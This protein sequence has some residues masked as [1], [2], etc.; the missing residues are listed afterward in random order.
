MKHHLLS[1]LLLSVALPAHAVG[2]VGTVTRNGQPVYP[3]DIDIVNRTTG[4]T[5]PIPGDTTTA[6]GSYNLVLP[7]GRYNLTFRP[8]PNSHAFDAPHQD[9]RVE[10]N[11]ITVNMSLL[12]GVYVSGRV[13][14]AAGAGVGAT[15]LRFRDASGLPPTSVQDDAAA[16]DGTF[17][18][19][20]LPGSWSIEVIPPLASHRAPLEVP[21]ASYVSDR[22]LGDIPTQAGALLTFSVTDASLFPLA[23]A[24][25]TARSLPDRDRVFTP[26]NSTSAG[27]TVQLVLPLGA[28]DLTAEPPGAQTLLYATLT[29]YGYNVAADAIV[30]NFA[31]PAGRQVSGKLTGAG[32]AAVVNADIDVDWMQSPAFPRVECA[33]DFTNA[34]GNFAVTLGAGTY[35]ITF[36]PPV[37]SKLVPLRLNN[38]TVGAPN[39]NLGTLTCATGHWLDVTVLNSSNGQPVAGANIDLEDAVTGVKLI[40]LDDVTNGAGFARTVS[41]RELYR[42]RVSPPDASMDTVFVPGFFRTL[43]D[44]AI[45]LY[46]APH[47][48]LGVETPANASL[49]LSAPWPNPAARGV[50]FSLSGTGTGELEILDLGGRRMATPWRGEGGAGTTARWDGRDEAGREVPNGVYFARLRMAGGTQ[51]RRLV[52]AR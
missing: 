46:M 19:L 34:L 23:G 31:L 4:A 17:R 40:T 24:K 25:V 28:H 52:V 15:N 29:Q 36:N 3:C 2:I 35:R 22:A 33:N 14:G 12:S 10:S 13:T 20:V 27:G 47:G 48:T 32:G 42:L 45:T 9:A 11:T 38:I 26:S 8:G 7:N 49:R 50:S 51:V 43:N 6:T 21:L 1:L 41:D 37:S 30:P 16:A 5:V 18:A 44:T 39:L